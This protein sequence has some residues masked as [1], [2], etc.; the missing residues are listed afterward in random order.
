MS[1]PQVNQQEQKKVEPVIEKKEPRYLDKCSFTSAIRNMMKNITAES[2]GDHI[3][4]EERKTGKV[5]EIKVEIKKVPEEIFT[6]EKGK[7]WKRIA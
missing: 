1:K 5:F 6:D 4:F 3:K 2:N 7:T